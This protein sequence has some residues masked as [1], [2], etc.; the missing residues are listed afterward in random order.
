MRLKVSYFECD[1]VTKVTEILENWEEIG[2]PLEMGG[3]KEKKNRAMSPINI[4]GEHSE[5]AA[6]GGI[7]VVCGSKTKGNLGCPRIRG[8]RISNFGIEVKKDVV[9]R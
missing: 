8:G 1:I 4:M 9:I 6:E 2:F 5:E 3:F 7:G